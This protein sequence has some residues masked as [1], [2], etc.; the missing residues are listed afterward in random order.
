MKNLSLTLEMDSGSTLSNDQ[1]NQDLAIMKSGT[2][3]TLMF[4][5]KRDPITIEPVTGS[6]ANM[7]MKVNVN[8]KPARGFKLGT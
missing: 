2:A 3:I 7:P 1:S 8:G 4:Q 5:K 6:G